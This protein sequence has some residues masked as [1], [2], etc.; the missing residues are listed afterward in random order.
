[1]EGV[2]EDNNKDKKI[3]IPENYLVNLNDNIRL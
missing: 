3:I 2:E 1:M